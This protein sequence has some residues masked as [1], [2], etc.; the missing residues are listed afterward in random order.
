[1]AG[2]R[3]RGLPA[4]ASVRRGCRSATARAT[5][6]RALGRPLRRGLR[7][8]VVRRVL[9][10]AARIGL[11]LAVEVVELLAGELEPVDG[12]A[13]LVV[14]VVA[15]APDH[16]HAGALAEVLG[17]VLG[18]LAPQRPLD[19]GRFLGPVVTRTAPRVADDGH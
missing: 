7:R 19:R 4:R 9:T 2:R 5:A 3:S 1:M 15:Q 11:G 17:G 16:V 18:L 14:V 8:V 12:A 13:V 6:R 10:A